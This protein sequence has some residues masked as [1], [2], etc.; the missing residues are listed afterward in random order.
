MTDTFTSLRDVSSLKTSGY[1]RLK[2][3]DEWS[4]DVSSIRKT[5]KRGRSWYRILCAALLFMMVWVFWRR[6]ERDEMRRATPEIDL[7]ERMVRSWAQYAPAYPVGVYE[8][9]AGCVITQVT[10]PSGIEC[11][12]SDSKTFFRLIL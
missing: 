6:M 2:P 3:E 4:E 8:P 9:P 5:H 7:P 11:V 12:G 10:C 1:Q